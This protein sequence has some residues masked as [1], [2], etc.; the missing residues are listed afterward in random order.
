MSATNIIKRIKK[1]PNKNLEIV[2]ATEDMPLNPNNPVTSEITKNTSAQYIILL[3]SYF[4]L[5]KPTVRNKERL[6][7]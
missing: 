3:P 2:A 7:S 6:A 1:S 4:L 5:H